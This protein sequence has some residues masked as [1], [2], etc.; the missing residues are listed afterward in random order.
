MNLFNNSASGVQ[1]YDE[2]VVRGIV[3]AV[4][5]VVLFIGRLFLRGLVNRRVKGI[6][7]EKFG[8]SDFTAAKSKGLMTEEEMKLVRKRFA[9]QQLQEMQ[10]EEAAE[11]GMPAEQLLHLYNADP[12]LAK[13][14][15]ERTNENT[16]VQQ[17]LGEWLD[18]KAN[19]ED[20]A[21]PAANRPA[22]PDA[23]AR[24]A[25]E[26]IDQIAQPTSVPGRAKLKANSGDDALDPKRMY[27]N[28]LISLEEFQ[29]L[30]TK[31]KPQA[32]ALPA[33]A[34]GKPETPSAASAKPGAPPPP[35]P[36]APTQPEAPR[37][38]TAG[39]TVDL[40]LLHSKGLISDEE[41][42]QL[43]A[44]MRSANDG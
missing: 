44:K 31:K 23:P 32:G 28:G 1:G 7:V 2:M 6:D 24:T 8:F 38:S 19:K 12:D 11:T 3:V 33:A 39:K 21:P 10:G 14:Q 37:S 15:F 27:A 20:G 34:P 36:P 42:T 25:N 40:E 17:S 16:L 22:A 26:M 35:R 13:E 29:M 18:Q 41:Y 30:M 43:I 9:E 5:L 4:L